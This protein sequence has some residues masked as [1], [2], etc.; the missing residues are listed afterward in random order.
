[1]MSPLAGQLG[2]VG[3]VGYTPIVHTTAELVPLLWLIACAVIIISYARRPAAGAQEN[4]PATSSAVGE[5]IRAA[6]SPG[7]GK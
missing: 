4:V 2:V 7:D 3:I 6:V 1:M 5:P